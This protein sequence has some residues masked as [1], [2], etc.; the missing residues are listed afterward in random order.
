LEDIR[1]LKEYIRTGSEQAFSEIVKCH[2][3]LV[4]STCLR[5]VGDPS[6]AEDAAQVVFVILAQKSRSLVR[7]NSLAG[8][9][10]LTSRLTA[11]SMLRKEI[12]RNRAEAK[13]AACIE[14]NPDWFTH[15][16]PVNDALTSLKP[17]DRQ[18]VLLRYFDGL[19]FEEI[20]QTL[21]VSE[22]V[23]Q[24][25]VVRAVDKM[26]RHLTAQGV[27]TSAILVA[28]L[29]QE[30]AKA[31]PAKC[32]EAVLR[33]HM[34][35]HAHVGAIAPTPIHGAANSILHGILV[36]RIA[37]TV[38]MAVIILALAFRLQGTPPVRIH[39]G[40]GNSSQLSP[41]EPARVVPS[42]IDIGA[43]LVGHTEN[44]QVSDYSPHA[45][46]KNGILTLTVAAEHESMPTA[47]QK[48]TRP[49]DLVFNPQPFEGNVPSAAAFS[50]S[51]PP[52]A[53]SVPDQKPTPTAHREVTI[54]KGDIRKQPARFTVDEQIDGIS[55]IAPDGKRIWREDYLPAKV[56]PATD[57]R[58]KR[59]AAI[60]N[61]RET[62]LAELKLAAAKRIAALRDQS[63]K[64]PHADLRAQEQTIRDQTV[65]QTAAVES[66]AGHSWEAL[67]SG[68][69]TMSI[70]VSIDPG[71][72]EVR[73][74]KD[75]RLSLATAD[76]GCLR[77]DIVRGSPPKLPK[78]ETIT[79]ILPE[80]IPSLLN[81]ELHVTYRSHDGTF[82]V[83]AV[84]KATMGKLSRSFTDELGSPAVGIRDSNQ[85]EDNDILSKIKNLARRVPLGLRHS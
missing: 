74:S 3:K 25:R 47:T 81:G 23:A 59:G 9:L 78:S 37:A 76:I 21:A 57:D 4:Y 29:T 39:F 34:L 58:G 32:V 51:P 12:R 82:V 6:L 36:R 5:E 17:T 11:R 66:M 2:M 15:E 8:W 33:N 53:A 43:P 60:S 19:S 56:F 72:M 35:A 7:Y 40:A 41:Q 67:M 80:F 79:P 63:G 55:L 10:F 18:A 42:S 70:T 75:R 44:I 71:T 50:I 52:L 83:G 54:W 48:Q 49:D 65:L 64:G 30:S 46:I 20:A 1:T 85:P 68:P 22:S 45:R 26:R 31:A 69:L 13:A 38:A 16:R 73:D 24:K 61:Y 14:P 84:I 62:K 28:L 27:A 77:Y